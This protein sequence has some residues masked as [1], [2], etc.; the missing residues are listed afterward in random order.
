MVV[1]AN[2]ELASRTNSC[3][4]CCTFCHNVQ[5]DFNRGKKFC[6]DWLG[7]IHYDSCQAMCVPMVKDLLGWTEREI[8]FFYSAAG[9]VVSKPVLMK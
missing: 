1:I 4:A 3:P 6:A 7:D 8:S 5:P 2:V 9:L